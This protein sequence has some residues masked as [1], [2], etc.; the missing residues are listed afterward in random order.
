[1]RESKMNPITDKKLF[2]DPKVLPT[3]DW[4]ISFFG[5][6]TQKINQK[7]IIE[8]DRHQ[9]FEI[10]YVINGS[11]YIKL[12]GQTYELKTGDIFLIPPNF[13]HQVWNDQP[14]TEYFCAHFDITDPIF[15]LDLISFNAFH[16]ERQ[17]EENLKLEPFVQR[18]IALLDEDCSDFQ[19]KMVTQ[20][21][22]SEFLM[23]LNLLMNDRKNYIAADYHTIN[24]AKQISQS[25]LNAFDQCRHFEDHLLENSVC[26][27]QVS[28]IIKDLGISP[29]YGYEIFKKNFGISPRKFLTNLILEEA[30]TLL[31]K[32]NLSIE[33]ISRILGYSSASHFSR[34]F[35]RWTKFSPKSYRKKYFEI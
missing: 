5:G 4:T 16:Y 32:P 19:K 1:M 2:P 33:E 31:Q 3:I 7:W 20:I 23:S 11:E 10:L 8:P 12:E 26:D 34:Q 14:E 21:I 22:L 6:H 13:L 35:K 30:Q 18:W 25:I 28:E 24:Y 27:I 15:S 29:E 9:A 17:T